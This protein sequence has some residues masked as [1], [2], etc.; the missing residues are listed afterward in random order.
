MTRAIKIRQCGWIAGWRGVERREKQEISAQPTIRESHRLSLPTPLSRFQHTR[1]C[2]IYIW[3]ITAAQSQT[4]HPGDLPSVHQTS[5]DR[6]HLVPC[7]AFSQTLIYKE[8]NGLH[9]NKD[10]NIPQSRRVFLIFPQ[11]FI[12]MQLTHRGRKWTTSSA[13]YPPPVDE[14][15][16]SDW[17]GILS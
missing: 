5:I 10:L 15:Y 7:D 8:I 11:Q 2:A 16:V 1:H 6:V 13:V 9:N 12:P 3:I 4:Y 14:L 17:L